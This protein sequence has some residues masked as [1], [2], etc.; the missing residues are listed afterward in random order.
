MSRF[1]SIRDL[2]SEI[3]YC[4]GKRDDAMATRS[5]SINSQRELMNLRM[6][7]RHHDVMA[8]HEQAI[9]RHQEDHQRWLTDL[10]EWEKTTSIEF[11]NTWREKSNER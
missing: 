9:A 11:A 1:M 2:D 3:E 5:A 4:T 6:I 10:A 7:A 8:E